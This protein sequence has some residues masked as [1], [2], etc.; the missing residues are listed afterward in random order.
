MRNITRAL[1]P[2]RGNQLRQSSPERVGKCSQGCSSDTT[3]IT[4]PEIRIPRRSRKNKRLPEPAE[5]RPKHGADVG[6]AASLRRPSVSDPITDEHEA[7]GDHHAELW[8]AVQHS[9]CERSDDSE[10]EEEG[11]AD[12]VDLCLAYGVVRG[13]LACDGSI[14]EPLE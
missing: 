2:E 10:G 7:G 12:P 5:E 11:D 8:A 1:H 14:G 6:S 4:E 3:S 13:R 9:D